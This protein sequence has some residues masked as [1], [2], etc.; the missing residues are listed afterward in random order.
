MRATSPSSAR[1]EYGRPAAE[2]AF[3]FFLKEAINVLSQIMQGFFFSVFF[4][5]PQ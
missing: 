3:F 5:F 2:D 4:I 1:K